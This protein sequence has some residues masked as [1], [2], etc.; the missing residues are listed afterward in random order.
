MIQQ[1]NP[2]SS[3]WGAPL[4][5]S[6]SKDHSHVR[7][8]GRDYGLYGGVATW[9]TQCSFVPQ[10]LCTTNKVSTGIAAKTAYQC[11]IPFLG[12][13]DA[14]RGTRI[15]VNGGSGGVGIFVIQIAKALGAIHVSA[16]CS[17]GNVEIVQSL[18]VDNPIDYK[19]SDIGSSLKEEVGSDLEGK[20]YDLVVDCVGQPESL[21][22][23]A[24][25]FLKAS[26][27]FVQIGASPSLGT[28]K[29]FAQRALQPRFLGGGKSK[30]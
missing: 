8:S 15:F 29:S 10:L 23:A 26:G 20:G 12:S 6:V 25:D 28:F 18:G 11:I 4:S 14:V 1:F 22:K 19:K 9:H 13:E 7:F 16:S 21:Y 30:W 24:D 17:T 2:P 5:P 27:Q 3:V